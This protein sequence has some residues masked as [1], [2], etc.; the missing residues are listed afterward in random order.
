MDYKLGADSG[1][2]FL[3]QAVTE[4]CPAPII[5]LTGFG[6]PELDLKAMSLG[7]ADF[8]NKNK[9]DPDILDRSVRYTLE[10]KRVEESIPPGTGIPAGHHR[11]RLG[12][13]RH[14]KEDG[15]PYYVSPASQRILGYVYEEGKAQNP[16]L[17]VHP[18]DLRRAQVFVDE[19]ISAP[20]QVRKGEFQVR[21]QDGSWRF[22]EVT[23]EK[24]F[25]RGPGF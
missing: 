3:S 23:G 5:L 19:L 9:L 15:V 18:D 25:L 22:L 8:I 16:F 20:G 11:E 6:D 24:P 13:S 21:H 1:L 10:H 14:I 17:Y 7:A 4:R 2:E 12:W